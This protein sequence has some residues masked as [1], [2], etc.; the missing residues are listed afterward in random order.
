MDVDTRAPCQASDRTVDSFV[1]GILETTKK[2]RAPIQTKEDSWWIFWRP[3]QGAQIVV[4]SG[5]AA[6]ALA[7]AVQ[8]SQHLLLCGC[9][10]A[11]RTDRLE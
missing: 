11:A 2:R 8:S 10:H 1:G 7:V 5:T 6:L 4:H 9:P 3:V